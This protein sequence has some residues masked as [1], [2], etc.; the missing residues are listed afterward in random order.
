MDGHIMWTFIPPG[1]VVHRVSTVNS[2]VNQCSQICTCDC[3][4]PLLSRAI[5]G[6]EFPEVIC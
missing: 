1:H 6:A 3:C 2:A 4:Y 5:S